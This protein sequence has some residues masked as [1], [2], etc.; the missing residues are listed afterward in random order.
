MVLPKNCYLLQVRSELGD[1]LFLHNESNES[2]LNDNCDDTTM[3][4]SSDDP[5]A[6][7]FDQSIHRPR[8][9]CQRDNNTLVECA[10]LLRQVCS[11]MQHRKNNDEYDVFGEHIAFQIRKLQN[12][13]VRKKATRSIQQLLFNYIDEDDALEK[14]RKVLRLPDSALE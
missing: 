12:E 7:N 11:T 1:P 2:A 14:A 4:H 10:C 9:H 6:G 3:F 5:L 13:S 8:S